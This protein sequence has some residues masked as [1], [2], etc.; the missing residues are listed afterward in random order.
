MD[1][2]V[3]P[4]KLSPE[5]KTFIKQIESQGGKGYEIR[6]LEQF[7]EIIICIVGN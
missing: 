2:K 3:G 4:D 1:F 5:Q 7:K 6:S